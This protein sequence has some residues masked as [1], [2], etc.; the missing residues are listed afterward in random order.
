MV[1]NGKI[2]GD[3]IQNFSALPA[4]R[5]ER[6]AQLAGSVDPLDA[7]ARFKAAVATIPNV[8]TEPGRPR[9]TCSTSTSSAR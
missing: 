3:T 4:R 2:F 8:V 1:G 9:S 5:V 7:I 6:T